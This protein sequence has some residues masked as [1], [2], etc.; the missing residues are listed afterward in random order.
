MSDILV[1]RLS[2]TFNILVRLKY[3]LV[4]EVPEQAG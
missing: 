1:T 4:V 3:F 2:F